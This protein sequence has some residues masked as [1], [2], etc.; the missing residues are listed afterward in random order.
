[1]I[2]TP[3]DKHAAL[4]TRAIHKALPALEK[5]AW[6]SHVSLGY[7]PNV[8][9]TEKDPHRLSPESPTAEHLEFAVSDASSHNSAEDSIYDRMLAQLE[10]LIAGDDL[11]IERMMEI[12]LEYETV[13]GRRP[14]GYEWF[15]EEAEK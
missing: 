14:P 7:V 8:L 6:Q 3:Q 4:T 15:F 2:E 1:M 13:Y 10:L 11:N 9:L 5:Y 12:A